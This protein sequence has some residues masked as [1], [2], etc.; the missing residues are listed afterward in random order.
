[1]TNSRRGEYKVRQEIMKQLF[2]VNQPNISLLVPVNCP[3]A[4]SQII[5]GF[6]GKIHTGN[7]T[8]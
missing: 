5:P 6:Y 3:Q 2:K 8:G 1:M 7:V 4:W